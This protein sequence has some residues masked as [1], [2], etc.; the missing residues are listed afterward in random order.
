MKLEKSSFLISILLVISIQI[1]VACD[2][3]SSSL[4]RAIFDLGSLE[5][6]L[7]AVPFP[8]DLRIR[9][10]GKLDL[11]GLT[12]ENL[13]GL[14]LDAVKENRYGGFGLNPVVYLRF[15][16]PI[17][18]RCLPPSPR[19]TTWGGASVSLVN[20]DPGS[21][22]Y[23][24]RIPVRLRWS[25]AD[26]ERK[27]SSYIRANHLAVLPVPGF[28]LDPQTVYAVILTESLR[29][30]SGD[31]VQADRD[32]ERVLSEPAP[33]SGAILAR[34]HSVYRP[35]RDHLKR[36][37]LTGV[38]SA[39]VFTTG[40]PTDLAGRAR[41][42]VLRG[43]PPVASDL[44]FINETKTYLELQGTYEAT[45]F[46]HGKPPFSTPETG[47][48]IKTDANGDPVPARTESL[49]FSV[50]VPTT[51][52][53]PDKGWPVVLYAH[54]TSGD[55][56]RYITD[57]TARNLALVKDSSN[58]VIA[59]LAVVGVDLNLHGDRAPEGSV[60]ELT[61]INVLNPAAGVDSVIQ[62]GI[63]GFSLVR[64][65][66][67]LTVDRARYHE[68][69]GRKGMVR[70]EPP[71]R[72]D[73][74]RIYFIG[75]SQGAITG[76]VFLA[77]E[78]AIKGAVL[79]GAGG[80]AVFGMLQKTQPINF[81]ALFQVALKENVDQF[82]PIINLVQQ[83]LEPSDTVNYG[84]MLLH[85]RPDS[86]GPKHILL[87]QGFVD[88]Y[89]PNDSADALATA[90]GLPI[91]GQVLRPVDSLELLGLQPEPLPLCGNLSVDGVAI[92]GGLVQNNATLKHGR[93][94]TA[95]HDCPEDHGCEEGVCTHVCETSSDCDKGDYCDRGRCYDDGHFVIFKNKRAIRQV[96]RFLA[97][98]ARDGTPT[99]VE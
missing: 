88:H 9:E 58:E 72:F 6:E 74:D 54:G 61:F 98:L 87:S 56:R 78:P 66:R 14:Y 96:S 38:I 8:N 35:L 86:I 40:R 85:R 57:G 75:H 92:T 79:S 50:S 46:Q 34:A 82:H 44:V 94:C 55:F 20:I 27:E 95:A 64:M 4:T 77:H 1:V 69:S 17:D 3:D 23:G 71:V 84:R 21:E 41:N 42:V 59:R 16:G 37:G 18:P 63:D 99:L 11:A 68:E 49:R 48:L 91:A 36:Q 33:T 52:S 81:K 43:P 65:I 24:L 12:G 5:E 13:V 22:D 73:P 93:S 47:G 29:D 51:G 45:N 97:T 80:L 76:P 90:I 19:A 67:G 53:M 39:A 31:P 30:P 2:N 15:S 62:G 7:F 26:P 32:F 70:F 28:S 25:P 10:D 60:S 89:T 83:G